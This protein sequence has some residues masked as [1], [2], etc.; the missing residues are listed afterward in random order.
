MVREEEKG[1]LIW[2]EDSVDQKMEADMINPD[3]INCIAFLNKK[4]KLQDELLGMPSP[5]HVCWGQRLICDF[6]SGSTTEPKMMRGS[7]FVRGVESEPKSASY[8]YSFPADADM[9]MSSHDDAKT[10][11]S[12]T[13]AHASAEAAASSTFSDDSPSQIDP[14]SSESRSPKK[15]TYKES[16]SPSSEELHCLYREYGLKLSDNYED[17]LLE[18]GSHGDCSLSGDQ[19]D[20]IEG[21]AD[22][23]VDDQLY[24]NGA[25]DS[26]FVLSSGRWSVNQDSQEGTKKL[27]IDKEFEQYFSALML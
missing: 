9:S 5:K 6:P 22:E 11:L 24:S 25:T 7:I 21:C 14:Y 8:I 4:R 12:Y 17:H 10:Y 20:V 15:A 16:E 13:K 19:N 18:F 3:D 27:T 26:N 1:N 2:F 23:G